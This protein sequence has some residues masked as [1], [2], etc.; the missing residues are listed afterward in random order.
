MEF[1]RRWSRC[2]EVVE[3]ESVFRVIYDLAF[4]GGGENAGEG[5][6]LRVVNLSR[7]PVYLFNGY[8][9]GHVC[10]GEAILQLK[11]SGCN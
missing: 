8:G 11:R 10:D 3:F 9:F 1:V 5:Q 2:W 6:D 4:G 7:F